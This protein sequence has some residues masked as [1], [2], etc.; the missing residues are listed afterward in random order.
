MIKFLEKNLS[1]KF[2]KFMNVDGKIHKNKT[3]I[4][5]SVK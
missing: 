2:Y 3:W 1:D 5:K 4:T